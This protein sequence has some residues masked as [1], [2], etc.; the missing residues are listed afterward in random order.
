MGI[1]SVV[2]IE[3]SNDDTKRSEEYNKTFT[4]SKKFE[5]TISDVLPK[6]TVDV[7]GYLSATLEKTLHA[8]ISSEME[9]SVEHKVVY[10]R[11]DKLRLLYTIT[12]Q[13]TVVTDNETIIAHNKEI[14]PK[15]VLQQAMT[16][17]ELEASAMRYAKTY[18]DEGFDGTNLMISTSEK[19]EIDTTPN[20]GQTPEF[21]WKVGIRKIE[22]L[23]WNC[24]LTVSEKWQEV[25][26]QYQ[27]CLHGL[28]KARLVCNTG[29]LLSTGNWGG[30]VPFWL[31]GRKFRCELMYKNTPEKCPRCK[32]DTKW[33]I[34]DS[35][36]PDSYPKAPGYY[37][38]SKLNEVALHYGHD[39]KSEQGATVQ[40]IACWYC[41]Q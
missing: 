11:S 21:Q 14:V 30:S 13:V 39:G 8:E 12:R 7:P 17:D 23:Q 24:N 19:L 41:S 18:A 15:T 20:T 4:K 40:L 3:A 5:K 34:V 29:R 16:E 28:V 9:H 6:I 26:S 25:P 32:E 2:K 27:D 36:K 10:E 35:D 38:S 22:H 37:N 33:K 1:K 31:G